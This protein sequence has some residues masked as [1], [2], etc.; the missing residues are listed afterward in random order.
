M[1]LLLTCLSFSVKDR[2][3]L[4]KELSSLYEKELFH[5][6]LN[7]LFNDGINKSTFLDFFKDIPFFEL[8]YEKFI[9]TLLDTSEI[10]FDNKDVINL[11]TSIQPYLNKTQTLHEI[12]PE[13]KEW[14][15]TYKSKFIE[16][17]PILLDIAPHLCT[18]FNLDLGTIYN[19]YDY[20]FINKEN[21]GVSIGKILN[22]IE[23]PI[24]LLPDISSFVSF[25]T[26]QKTESD[27][28]KEINLL[29]Q[30][31]NLMNKIKILKIPDNEEDKFFSM[32]HIID[33]I[34]SSIDLFDLTI[35]FIVKSTKKVISPLLSK[36]L[37]EK[38]D[39][40]EIPIYDRATELV[41]V[42]DIFQK[43]S[44]S[45]SSGRNDMKCTTYH[46]VKNVLEAIECNS[47]FGIKCTD[48]DEIFIHAKAFAST[49]ALSTNFPT[50]IKI[51]HDLLQEL[52]LFV[53]DNDKIKIL[54]YNFVPFKIIVRNLT[55]LSDLITNID[56]SY[57]FKFAFDYLNLNNIWIIAKNVINVINNDIPL[58]DFFGFEGQTCED[59]ITIIQHL[60]RL[61]GSKTS[62]LNKFPEGM[63]AEIVSV[64]NMIKSLSSSF[65][66]FLLNIYKLTAPPEKVREV[67]FLRFVSETGSLFDKIL[68]FVDKLIPSIIKNHP[69]IAQGYSLFMNKG[70]ECIGMITNNGPVDKFIYS[71]M[72]RYEV[73]LEMFVNGAKSF[74][75]EN[76][77]IE[78]IVKSIQPNYFLNVYE[79]AYKLNELENYNI[80]GF[81]DAISY[82]ERVD[83]SKITI[84]KILP[85]K[86]LVKNSEQLAKE[87]N[88]NVL[89]I[90]TI[91]KCLGVEKESLKKFLNEKGNIVVHTWLG[92][93]IS[94]EIIGHIINK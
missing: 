24:N 79:T 36:Y 40:S 75:D 5:D 20:I 28:F 76:T 61:A 1:L 50:D 23:F 92:M 30:Y 62:F 29:P 26:S 83:S 81:V 35:Q 47:K 58:C 54:N 46:I 89:F 14:F 39:I 87:M 74:V 66:D 48:D 67:N 31:D 56:D 2:L 72:G 44:F 38:I 60:S 85:I 12:N 25:F 9:D 32:S 21:D 84:N 4:T 71:L 80:K 17:K 78:T 57:N 59:L 90:N 43:Y 73:I 51:Y 34:S 3:S 42:L 52:S 41:N 69:E 64:V 68:T 8:K 33:C 18:I 45:C 86:T 70:H 6:N 10:I 77:T 63:R 13:I 11:L 55:K 15:L 22:I 19:L 93:A 88:E 7:D 53:S 49:I 94:I 82:N 16:L 65:S 37:L 27:F 91:A